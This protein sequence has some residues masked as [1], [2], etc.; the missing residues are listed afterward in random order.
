QSQR[1]RIQLRR[2][3]AISRNGRVC[4]RVVDCDR[5]RGKGLR[6]VSAALER[7]R[8][9]CQRVK[10]GARARAAIAQVESPLIVMDDLRDKERPAQNETEAEIPVGRFRKRLAVQ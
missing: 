5:A 8:D 1:G 4:S 10:G 7:G 3:N 9:A 6:E 2:R